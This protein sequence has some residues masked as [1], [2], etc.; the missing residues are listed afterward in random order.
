[1]PSPRDDRELV[2]EPPE[3]PER[4]GRSAAR[5]LSRTVP[6]EQI[7]QSAVKRLWRQ[8]SE[9]TTPEGIRPRPPGARGLA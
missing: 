7:A 6:F 2:L 3:E 4:R 5:E 8:N 1:L 9:D